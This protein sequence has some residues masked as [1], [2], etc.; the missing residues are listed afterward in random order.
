[1]DP[2]ALILEMTRVSLEIVPQESLQLSVAD[3]ELGLPHLTT[4]HPWQ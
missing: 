1:M 3:W 2:P 4:R